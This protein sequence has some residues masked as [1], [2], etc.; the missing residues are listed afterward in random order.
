MKLDL[1]YTKIN[2][3]DIATI[4]GQS[5]KKVFLRWN[6]VPHVAIRFTDINL[7]ASYGNDG[8]VFQ[9][10]ESYMVKGNRERAGKTFT[11][12]FLK[13]SMSFGYSK[14]S[15]DEIRVNILMSNAEVNAPSLQGYVQTVCMEVAI[16]MNGYGVLTDNCYEFVSSVIKNL[17]NA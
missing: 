6:L 10:Y 15:K 2:G 12:P 16:K 7:V 13:D 17:N 4:V 11:P 5:E 3:K 1:I 9:D 8:L 14:L